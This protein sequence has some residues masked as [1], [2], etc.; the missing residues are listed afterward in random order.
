[1]ISHEIIEEVREA[2]DIVEV[3]SSYLSFKRAG[4]NYKALCPFHQEKTPSFIISP[5]KQIY[6]CFGCGEGGNVF[7]FVMKMESLPFQEAV[8]FL[9]ERA[10]IKIESSP[11]AEEEDKKRYLLLQSNSLALQKFLKDRQSQAI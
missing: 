3:L 7:S 5:E 6:H 2:N 8:K 1:M 9:A 10:G 4:R 11:W